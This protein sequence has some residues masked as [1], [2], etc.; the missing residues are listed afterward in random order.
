MEEHNVC[1]VTSEQSQGSGAFCPFRLY[2]NIYFWIYPQSV[3]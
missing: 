2:S 3:Y 1:N